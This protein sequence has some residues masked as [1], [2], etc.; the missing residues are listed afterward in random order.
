MKLTTQSVL[1]K[2][3]PEP[4]LVVSKADGEGAQDDAGFVEGYLAVYGNIDSDGDIIMQGAFAKSIREVVAAGKVPLMAQHFAMGGG[5]R[6]VV[7]TITQAKEDAF[8]LWVHAE[9][10][11]DA[12]A[13]TIRQRVA[14]GHIKG[15]SVGF[16]PIRWKQVERENGRIGF[17]FEELALMEGTLTAFPA[18]ELAGIT[19]AKSAATTQDGT[20]EPAA[21]PEITEGK[22]A[23][24]M[25]PTPAT[26]A[27]FYAAETMCRA[28][29]IYL[30]MERN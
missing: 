7:G 1:C 14:A 21:A 27:D 29:A 24:G 20:T 2:Q 8:G 19:A 22:S 18:N 13:Q 5:A 12:D 25:A 15:L 11:P 30:M 26:D 4:R 23:G 9:F 16:R 6:D 3:N 10:S 17:D 28:N